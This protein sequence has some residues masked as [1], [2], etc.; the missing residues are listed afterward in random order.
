MLDLLALQGRVTVPA[1]LSTF[2]IQ[3]YVAAMERAHAAMSKLASCEP[4]STDQV[5]KCL[6]MGR[7]Q[8]SAGPN[9]LFR[10]SISVKDVD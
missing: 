8:K 1:C 10:V 2:L 3:E 5:E 7:G 4:W 9:N 6:Q